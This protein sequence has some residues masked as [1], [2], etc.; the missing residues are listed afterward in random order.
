MFGMERADPHELSMRSLSRGP[1][2]HDGSGSKEER[3]PSAAKANPD[4][5][6]LDRLAEFLIK[7]RLVPGN[8]LGLD[9]HED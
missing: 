4:W 7:P 9:P 3:P 8:A 2:E 1:G 6:Q 5:L